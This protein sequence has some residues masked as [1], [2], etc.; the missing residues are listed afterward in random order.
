[1]GSLK[2]KHT[3]RRGVFVWGRSVNFCCFKR[4]PTSVTVISFI[5]FDTV[6]E[7]EL[8]QIQTGLCEFVSGAEL[9][10]GLNK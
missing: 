8:R 9:E 6:Y 2:V 5:C 1:M 10:G 7:K 4:N 3:W